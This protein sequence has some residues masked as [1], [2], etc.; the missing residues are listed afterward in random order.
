MKAEI[1]ELVRQ[2]RFVVAPGLST[3]LCD[4]HPARLN[5]ADEAIFSGG[6]GQETNDSGRVRR[7][8][9]SPSMAETQLSGVTHTGPGFALIF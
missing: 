5:P 2:T 6:M 9:V 3:V 8:W 7:V 1:G 4:D